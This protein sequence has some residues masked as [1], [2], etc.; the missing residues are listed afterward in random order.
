M[1]D[2][3]S[4]FIVFLTII[5]VVIGVIKFVNFLLPS[6]KRT[7]KSKHQKKDRSKG[8]ELTNAMAGHGTSGDSPY[9]K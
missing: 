9:Y 8:D 7:L 3:V 6:K 5:V 2:N 1:S 4:G